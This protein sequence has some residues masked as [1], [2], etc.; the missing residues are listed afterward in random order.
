MKKGLVLQILFIGIAGALIF[1]GYWFSTHYHR[2]LIE[3]RFLFEASALMRSDKL[4]TYVRSFQ[5]A[6]ELSLLQACYDKKDHSTEVW[7][8]YSGTYV[9]NKNV[10]LREIKE[11]ATG[12]V[13][14]YLSAYIDFADVDDSRI[15]LADESDITGDKIYWDDNSV[16][17]EFDEISF[18]LESEELNITR[19]FIPST[20]LHTKFKRVFDLTNSFVQDDPIG[21]KIKN[22]DYGKSECTIENVKN[23]LKEN[24]LPTVEDDFNNDYED[25]KITISL[26]LIEDDLQVKKIIT[27][28]HHEGYCDKIGCRD[29]PVGECGWPCCRFNDPLMECEPWN[30]ICGNTESTCPPRDECSECCSWV[31]GSDEKKFKC[32]QVTATVKVEM[33]DISNNFPV[34]NQ[35]QGEVVEDY[36]GLIYLIKTGNADKC[37]S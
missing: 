29:F 12:H 26:E 20:V 36:L 6:V 25:E 1:E 8:D 9:P 27:T 7:L 4:E 17:V 15:T 28:E 37:H 30:C 18:E 2:E 24:T 3:R 5:S 10:F 31:P 13:K 21:K 35:A 22:A 19:D 16:S 11:K 14:D 34:Y 23:D 32:C 33:K